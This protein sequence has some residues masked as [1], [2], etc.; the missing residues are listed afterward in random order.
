M[1]GLHPLLALQ[2]QFPFRSTLCSAATIN[3]MDKAMNG[4]HPL[5]PLQQQFLGLVDLTRD[6][7]GSTGVRMVQ[8]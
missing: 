5:L 3:L 6:V 8:D 2:Q 1:N 4:L 7:G